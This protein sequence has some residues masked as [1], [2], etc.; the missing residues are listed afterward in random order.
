M[1]SLKRVLFC[2]INPITGEL[3]TDAAARALFTHRNTPPKNM[4]ISPAEMIYGRKIRDHLPN[5][6]REIR[7][8]WDECRKAREMKTLHRSNSDQTQRTLKPLKTGDSVAVQNQTG[9]KPKKWSNTGKIMEALPHRQYQVLMDGSRRLTLRNRKFLKSIPN[10]ARDKRD[11]SPPPKVTL[12]S[13]S[14]DPLHN[15]H[16]PSSPIA[17]QRSCPRLAIST[18]TPTA[19]MLPHI[20]TYGD[21]PT[22]ESNHR[23]PSSI[24]HQEEQRPDNTIPSLPQ[25][26]GS[27]PVPPSQHLRRSR[28]L[29]KQPEPQEHTLHNKQDAEP[30]RRS[31]RQSKKPVR[32]LEEL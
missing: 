4:C 11:T 28:G 16:Q 26:P 6:F 20:N 17:E 14:P 9:N 12:P 19:D 21:E 3:D 2:N 13:L 27:P 31:K 18:T 24:E 32:L 25:I 29:S 22:T 30:P 7:K 10:T 15:V 8:E 5:E 23:E 1:K